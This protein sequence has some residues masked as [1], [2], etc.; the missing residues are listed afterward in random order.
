[1]AAVVTITRHAPTTAGGAGR[2]IHTTDEII[3][4]AIEGG[5]TPTLL[6]CG[7]IGSGVINY[8]MK[9]MS[10]GYAIIAVGNVSA[11][12]VAES[13]DG[14]Q[15]ACYP[16][17]AEREYNIVNAGSLQYGASA[18]FMLSR[19]MAPTGVTQMFFHR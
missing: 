2:A 6:M 10:G 14:M 4:H 1:M 16:I 9:G 18:G 17:D 8:W 15:D 3:E 19:S 13:I 11:A 12:P 5:F 7:I